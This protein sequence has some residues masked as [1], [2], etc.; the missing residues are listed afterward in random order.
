MKFSFIGLFFVLGW[1]FVVLGCCPSFHVTLCL[2]HASHAFQGS[3]KQTLFPFVG[4]SQGFRLE[5]LWSKTFRL[6][7]EGFLNEAT[8]L[9]NL[10]HSLMMGRCAPKRAGVCGL[11]NVIVSAI[12]LCAFVGWIYAYLITMYRIEK[13]IF[14]S[15]YSSCSVLSNCLIK[16]STFPWNFNGLN[17]II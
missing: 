12:R 7:T 10:L 6:F 1:R 5:Y 15:W 4:C 13:V 9:F 16:A 17:D 14:F 2:L 3:A 8:V 11:Y